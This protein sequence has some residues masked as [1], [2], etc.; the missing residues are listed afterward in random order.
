[1]NKLF[2]VIFA[3]ILLFIIALSNAPTAQADSRCRNATIEGSFGI[4]ATGTILE[5]GPMQPGLFAS[6]GL[7]DFDGNGNLSTRQ[8]L[9]LNGTI[10]PGKA[11]GTYKVEQDCTLTA[12]SIDETSGAQLSISG[13]IVKRGTEIPIISTDPYTVVTG[14]L[15]KVR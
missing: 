5:G 15:K 11:A 1:M 4:Q 2:A 3:A 13:V 6:N 14:I 9:S 10:V 12:K 8:T 7:I